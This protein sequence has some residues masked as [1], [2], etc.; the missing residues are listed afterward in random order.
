MH[1]SQFGFEAMFSIKH[2]LMGRSL[3]QPFFERVHRVCLRGMNYGNGAY[4]DKSGEQSV[5]RKLDV[6]LGGEKRIVVFDVGAN[7]GQYLNFFI[8]NYTGNYEIHCFEPS[9]F[10]FGQLKERFQKTQDVILNNF[11]LG[12]TTTALRLFYDAP[13]DTSASFFRND[14]DFSMSGGEIYE[15]VRVT[16]LDEYCERERIPKIDFLKV[17]VEG[18]EYNVL[19]GAA[20]LLR[21]KDIS[22]I[23]FE[24]GQKTLHASVCVMDFFNLLSGY[25]I[26]RILQD[27]LREIRYQEQFE[28]FLTTNYLAIRQDQ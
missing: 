7:V 20:G 23:Q 13:G 26:Y 11:G 10:A 25:R 27:G 1:L 4:P 22:V 19:L 5:I 28:I 18:N 2:K 17:D 24:I 8:D 14:P 15:D 21:R 6:L 9:E 3:L 16:T 12:T